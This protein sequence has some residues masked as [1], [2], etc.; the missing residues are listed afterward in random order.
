MAR[1]E[2]AALKMGIDRY[3]FIKLAAANFVDGWE[4][5][6]WDFIPHDYQLRILAS[7][8]RTKEAKERHS[9][10]ST[11]EGEFII[12]PPKDVILNDSSS[13]IPPEVIAAGDTIDAILEAKT[14]ELESS[15][16]STQTPPPASVA[17]PHLKISKVRSKPHR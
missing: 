10:K 1:V 15:E 12:H 13:S 9:Q 3:D 8:G 4:K 2:A 16:P 17:R 5:Y 14:R 6:G 11:K 7:D